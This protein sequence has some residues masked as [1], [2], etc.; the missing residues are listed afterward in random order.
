MFLFRKDHW[1]T[2]GIIVKIVTKSLGDKFFKRK[3]V[4]ERVVDKYAAHVKLVDD[5]VKLKLDQNHLETVIPSTG[6]LVKFVNGA[7]NG[8]TGV[9]KM[10]DVEGYC[11]DVEVKYTFMSVS[12][13]DKHV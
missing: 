13:A 4:V 10:I 3:A 6:R 1:L 8:Q 11:C 9:L 7:Y 2:E 5:N 12:I